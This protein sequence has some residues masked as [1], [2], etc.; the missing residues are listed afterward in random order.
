MYHLIWYVRGQ[1]RIRDFP[2]VVFAITSGFKPSHKR[3]KDAEC[4]Q[5]LLGSIIKPSG[6]AAWIWVCPWVNRNANL[7]PDPSQHRQQHLTS[8]WCRVGLGLHK[9]LRNTAEGQAWASLKLMSSCWSPVTQMFCGQTWCCDYQGNQQ[10][11]RD[12][13]CA[14][15]LSFVPE[16]KALQW[17][18][19]AAWISSLELQS[20]INNG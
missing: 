17:T 14:S 13:C 2:L 6:A 3:M 10:G 5:M 18:R 7:G 15:I 20:T 4:Y 1:T 16:F 9:F 12:L 8:N 19:N 11:F